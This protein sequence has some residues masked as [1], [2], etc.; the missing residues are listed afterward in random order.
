MIKQIDGAYVA[1]EVRFVRQLH[2]GT[3]LILEGETDALI[4][5]ELIDRN[6][7]E[8]QIGFGKSNV[9][10]ALDRLEDEGFPG[11]VA[12]IDADFDRLI[13]KKYSLE[14][15]YLTD[16]HDLDL[17]IFSSKA[18]DKYLREHG[19]SA[20]CEEISGDNFT[21]IRELVLTAALPLSCCRFISEYQGLRLNF[22]DLL[23]DELVSER[24][25]SVA[26][27]EL[28]TRLVKRSSTRCTEKQLKDLVQ[29]ELVKGHDAYELRNGH[30][31]ATI[32]GIALRR[33][34]GRRKHN[35][36]WGR[37]IEAGLR[38][39]FDRNKL[40]ETEILVNLKQWEADN[41]R[42]RIFAA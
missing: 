27:D 18:L 39:A 33:L 20:L 21:A 14:N 35:Q 31:A 3:I 41:L 10:D 15:L 32:L 40:N 5:D 38:L 13:G 7:C 1:A 24:D 17:T 25:L 23:L 28:I 11:V 22:N 2:K 12:I 36:T 26:C 30:D 19:D 29:S 34:I 8:I 4:F 37:E 9:I 42:Y 16:K 6:C